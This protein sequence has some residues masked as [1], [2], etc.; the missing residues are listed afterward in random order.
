MGIAPLGFDYC[1]VEEIIPR[2]GGRLTIPHRHD[3]FEVIWFTEGAGSHMVEFANYDLRPGMLFF[4]PR[5][6]VHA[7]VTTEGLKGHMLRFDGAFLDGGAQGGLSAMV[8]SLFKIHASPVRHIPGGREDVFGALMALMAEEAGRSGELRHPEK[9]RSLLSAFLIESERALP[10][11]DRISGIDGQAL[12]SYHRFMELLEERIHRHCGVGQYAEMMGLTPKKLGAVCRRVSGMT[13]KQVIQERVLLEA[14]RHLRESGLD[15]QEV[16][17]RLGFEDPAYFS[18]FFKRHTGAS[19]SRFRSA[20]G[21]K[22]Q[23]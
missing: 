7:F 16:A 1:G 17:Y 3:Y 20:R 14:K 10:G 6:Q 4:F 21:E 18:R 8:H 23:E 11:G 19:P 5:N 13:A 9:L 12:K 22:V 15:V 2:M